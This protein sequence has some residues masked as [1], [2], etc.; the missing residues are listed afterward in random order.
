MSDE[1]HGANIGTVK[2]SPASECAPGTECGSVIVPKDYFNPSAGTASIAIARFKA[3]KSPRR[4]TLFVNPG[5]PGAPG[6]FLAS[7][8]VADLLGEDWDLLGFDPRGIGK[9]SPQIQCFNSSMDYNFFVAN[10]VL[11]Q[12]G[13]TV[14]SSSNLSDPAI[15]AL[16]VDQSRELLALEKVQAEL[17]AKNMGDELR[18][19][20]SAT[21]VRDL[22][23]M[24]TIFDGKNA[25]INYWGGSYGSLLGTYL[26][27]M[28]PR[29][30]GFVAIDGALDPIR[31]P[32][33][34]WGFHW[35]ASAEKTYRF[36]LTACS[37]AGPEACP[38]AQYTDEPYEAIESRLESFFDKLALAPL[39]VPFGFR[40][41]VLTSGAARCKIISSFQPG[42][43]A[44][45]D[46]LLLHLAQ[47]RQWSE[48]AVAFSQAMAGNEP[49]TPHY[50]SA[51]L[52]VICLDAPPARS[53]SD[54]PTA[55][56]IA[57][58]FLWTMREMS[59]HF[60]AGLITPIENGLRVNSLMPDSTRM[61]IQ[62]GPGHCSLVLPTLCTLKLVRGYFAGTL[63]ENGTICETSYT[64]P[65]PS[66]PESNFLELNAED[67]RLLESARAVG[68]LMQ[69]S[70]RS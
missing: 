12:E 47:P 25:K 46:R 37:R 59:P 14:P 36:Y 27:N 57:L 11:Q 51:G 55:E 3:T 63:P 42:L 32:P 38:L 7:K 5:R 41:G 21:V 13:L 1:R 44:R 15:E 67:T 54:M 61:I 2:W 64:F 65:D 10:T 28:F 53:R 58:Q 49:S 9:T 6:T 62:D 68:R 18:Y 52:N 39:P 16:L 29:R 60:G 20:G 31:S 19:M 35:L 50:D 24:A 40:P 8:M 45:I 69:D 70:H 22:D 30:T 34:K 66:K 23:L 33:H 48:S 43:N 17:C 4:G 26:V 56:D